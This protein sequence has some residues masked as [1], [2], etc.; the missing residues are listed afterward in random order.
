MK[1]TISKIGIIF[2][3]LIF[4]LS[5]VACD[6]NVNEVENNDFNT[7]DGESKYKKLFCC[8]STEYNNELALF[9]ADLCEASE[10]HTQ[11][12]II[13]KMKEYDIDAPVGYNYPDAPVIPILN[14]EFTTDGG[15]CAF[16]HIINE[17]NDATLFIVARG[18]MSVGEMIGDFFHGGSNNSVKGK[19]V[20]K[21]VIDFKEQL[22]S[23][24]YD[25]CNN[26]SEIK[27]CRNITFLITGH[28]L[29][30]AAA[31]LFG[32]DIT[33]NINN[34]WWKDKTTKYNIY[35]YTFGAIKVIDST[36]NINV[37]EGFENI[38]NIYNYYD[39]FG[40][41]GDFARANVSDQNFKFGH[42][43]I[44]D[45]LEKEGG[46]NDHLMSNYKKSLNKQMPELACSETEYKEENNPE[47]DALNPC[48]IISDSVSNFTIQ[49]SWKSIGS[50]G[51][52]QAQP[53]ATV[54]FNETNCNFYS[55]YDTY[56]FYQENGKWRL[57]CKNVLWQDIQYFTVTILDIDNIEIVHDGSNQKTVLQRIPY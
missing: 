17:Q 33:A 44:Y 45:N 25:Y 38:H 16:G 6:E 1:N 22:S 53:G 3:T 32:A 21:N 52:G 37:S 9:S 51:F 18:T 4:C 24:L 13:N 46:I 50:Y 47:N 40:P 56:Q 55:P 31:N 7:N 29:G 43:E 19:K 11:E 5:F 48:E 39:S 49:G 42:T 15:A 23:C 14:W 36:N 41:N 34:N 57:S 2:L 20:W 27:Q 12:A 30:G 35:V 8:P 54:T 28:S 26:N 10:N